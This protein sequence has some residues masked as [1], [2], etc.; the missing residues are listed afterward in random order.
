MSEDLKNMALDG[1]LEALYRECRALLEAETAELQAVGKLQRLVNAAVQDKKWAD[2]EGIMADIYK[3]GERIGLIEA[4]RVALMDSSQKTSEDFRFY[5]FVTRFPEE[6]RRT[7]SDAYREMK[8]EAAK[9]R[10]AND[11]LNAYLSEQIALAGS[12]LEAAF[13]DRRGTFYGRHGK[14]RHADMRSVLVNKSF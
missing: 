4:K 12:I 9:I 3:V 13:P 1:D 7:L 5:A 14:V 11:A 8:L 2:Y 6:N 10:F